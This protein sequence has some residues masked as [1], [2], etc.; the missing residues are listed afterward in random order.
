MC[1]SYNSDLKNLLETGKVVECINLRSMATQ[2]KVTV[3][4]RYL[5]SRVASTSVSND[6]HLMVARLCERSA[7]IECNANKKIT[8]RAKEAFNTQTYIAR[9]SELEPWELDIMAAIVY[10]M[11]PW[12]DQD[13]LIPGTRTTHATYQQISKFFNERNYS[14]MRRAIASFIFK[15]HKQSFLCE[16][17]GQFSPAASADIKAI[18]RDAD[19]RIDS[20]NEELREMGYDENGNKL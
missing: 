8:K 10:D 16:A 19:K 13:L 4:Y 11:V 2:T 12:V 6:S 15:E 20:I 5:E 3:E 7:S 9:T 1:W 14:W 17:A 18:R